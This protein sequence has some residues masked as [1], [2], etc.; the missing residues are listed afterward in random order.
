MFRWSVAAVIINF[1]KKRNGEIHPGQVFGTE[2]SARILQM[3]HNEDAIIPLFIC[4]AVGVGSV[5][6]FRNV[7]EWVQVVPIYT[8]T[9]GLYYKNENKSMRSKGT[10]VLIIFW[11]AVRPPYALFP[12][13]TCQI[14]ILTCHDTTQ[15]TNNIYSPTLHDDA[16]LLAGR[17]PVVDRCWVYLFPLAFVSLDF[18]FLLLMVFSRIRGL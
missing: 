1:H 2:K 17:G 3:N 18:L 13:N 8:R 5:I 16:R 15:S 10:V 6:E 11:N 12:Q 7:C 9:C 14:R 4:N